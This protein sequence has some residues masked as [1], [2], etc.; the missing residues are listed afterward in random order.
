LATG[1][2]DET[3]V[4]WDAE[5]GE[6]LL[7]LE[8]DEELVSSVAWS[9]DG[10]RL[11]VS[12]GRSIFVWNAE[13][14]EQVVNLDTGLLMIN[15]ICWSPDG[16]QLASVSWDGPTTVWDGETG[17]QLGVLE[18]D[19]NAASVSWS[20]DGEYLAVGY[21]QQSLGA[22]VWGAETGER[23]EP[24]GADF[25]PTTNATWSEDGNLLIASALGAFRRDPAIYM[26]DFETVEELIRLDGLVGEARDS[27]WSPGGERLA[28]EGEDGVTAWEISAVIPR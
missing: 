18:G 12:G 24:A 2:W 17:E 13:T 14:G 21:D 15:S 6:P 3:V 19:S 16:E 23:L 20:P 4:V 5:S 25:V 26:W 8:A 22:V 7:K 11:A 1:S 28:V 27:A 9:P 10:S